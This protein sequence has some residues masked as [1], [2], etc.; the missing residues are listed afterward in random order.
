MSTRIHSTL[1]SLFTLALLA[2][3]AAPLAALEPNESNLVLLDTENPAIRDLAGL[4]GGV[5]SEIDQMTRSEVDT[6]YENLNPR[7]KQGVFFSKGL[8]RYTAPV[9]QGSA[10]TFTTYGF[11]LLLPCEKCVDRTIDDFLHSSSERMFFMNDRYYQALPSKDVLPWIVSDKKIWWEES[12]AAKPFHFVARLNNH[13]AG[14][15]APSSEVQLYKRFE[16]PSGLNFEE[17]TDTGYELDRKHISNTA[18]KLVIV[19]HGWNTAPKTDPFAYDPK[20]PGWSLLLENMSNQIK[21]RANYA[22]GWDLYAYQWG[23]DSYTGGLGAMF[24]A[25]TDISTNASGGVGVGEENGTQAAEIGYQHGL[26]L[27]KLIRDHCTANLIDLEKVHFIA[28]SAGTWVARSAS[29]YL[30]ATR[31]AG[32]TLDQQ[33]T[34]LDPYMPHEGYLGWTA[35]PVLQGGEDSTLNKLDVED[36]AS[37]VRSVR[38]ENLFSIDRLTYGTN[39]VFWKLLSRQPWQTFANRQVGESTLGLGSNKFSW[40]GHSGPVNFFAYTADPK[41]FRNEF[42]EAQAFSSQLRSTA[43][44]EDW[45]K[46]R[47]EDRD[48]AGWD[49]SLFMQ[50]YRAN[51]P[52]LQQQLAQASSFSVL[53]T[54]LPLL[55]SSP[56]GPQYT[57]ASATLTSPWQQI[58]VDVDS[59]GWVRAMLMPTNGGAAEL[60]GPVR[61]EPDG[62]FSIDLSD[63]TVLAGIFDTSVTPVAVALTIDGVPFGQKVA[64]AQGSNAQAGFDAQL[65]AAGNMVFSMVLADGTAGMAVAKDAANTGW[66]GAGVGTVDANGAFTVTGAD[67]LQITGQLQAGGGLNPQA[68]TVVAPL[69]PE[70]HVLDAVG[71]SLATGTASKGCGSVQVGGSSSALAITIKNTGTV[72]LTDLAVSIDGTNAADFAVTGLGTTTLAPEAS[73][74]LNLTFSPKAVGSRTARLRIAS[75]DANENPFDI[76]LTGTGFT[77]TPLASTGGAS[78]LLAAGAEDHY[79]ITLPGPGIL[80]V[81]SEGGTDTYGSLLSTG[82]G[83]LDEDNDSDLQVNFRASTVVVAG[84]YFIRVKGGTAAA[85]G[86]YTVR[87]RFIS[88]EESIQISFLERTGDGVNLGFTN[89]AGVF[90]GIQVSD[91]LQNWT[92]MKTVTGEGAEMLVPLSGFGR[93]P[94]AFLRV[95]YPR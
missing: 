12:A 95:S 80:I 67:G 40:S 72:D 43:E 66:E 25:I 56:S 29:L 6:V 81:W 11:D 76:T 2:A 53:R 63:G 79:R 3:L 37:S 71:G 47:F 91:D 23:Q 17:A 39:E 83:V 20:A 84:D 7:N 74:T 54:V 82:G 44:F 73:L 50:E 36:W 52:P 62:S 45:A 64:K 77:A 9:G 24:G 90:Y 51:L 57:S 94:M 35:N 42:N 88:A 89:T 28:H 21:S 48:P 78:S 58:L 5:T 46:P 19:V 92:T 61:P 1:A 30:N 32:T 68:T 27:G 59:V 33:I 31:E 69:V 34:L 70:I 49:Y 8:S 93:F 86:G 15:D 60:A 26:V 16:F 75:N 18:T 55:Q 38:C 4:V 87:S 22:P 65:N 41:N 85:A 13:S 10:N 14:W